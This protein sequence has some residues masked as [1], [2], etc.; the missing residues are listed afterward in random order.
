[1]SKGTKIS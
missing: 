1:M